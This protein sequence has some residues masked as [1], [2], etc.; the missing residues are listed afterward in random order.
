[1][2]NKMVL[3]LLLPAM[4]IMILIAIVPILTVLNF[5]LLD[6]FAGTFAEPI[7][8]ENY[9][10]ALR[11]PEFMSSIERQFLFTFTVLLIE[12]PLGVSLAFTLPKG[13]SV[14]TV[15]VLIL[16]GIPLLIPWNVVG[17]MW[18]ILTRPDVGLLPAVFSKIG[19]I[20]NPSI[21][22]VQAWWTMIA[23]DV[24][25]W[26]PLVILLTYAGLNSIPQEFF[27]AARID[28]ASPWSTFRYITLPKLKYVL[29][30]GL[31]LR[32]MDSFRMYDE[33]FLLS[34]GGPGNT[35]QL[36]SIYT[37]KIARGS[38]YGF[39]SAVSLIYLFIVVLMCFVLYK[40]VM[41]MGGDKK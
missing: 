22:G 40:T 19:L 8:W 7:G 13:R 21:N 32:V 29:V 17:I 4:F 11:D 16:L 28:S 5:S 36:L 15:I 14:W 24:W 26:T 23:M 1:M 31:L 39:S 27:Q 18:R 12:F 25:H 20:Y 3:F 33:A 35:T 10:N 41:S 2:K 6:L 38:N 34:A 9:I 30:I 37:S